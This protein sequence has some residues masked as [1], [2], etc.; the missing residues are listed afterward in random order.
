MRGPLGSPVSALLPSPVLM[1]SDVFL[2]IVGTTAGGGG[3]AYCI[4]SAAEGVLA[5][6]W[7]T[8]SGLVTSTRIDKH[9][10]RYGPR[11][12]PMVTYTYQVMGTSH[13]GSRLSFWGDR[14]MSSDGAQKKL[15][16]YPPGASITVRYHPQRPDRSVLEHG[17]R[18]RPIL[19]ASIFA[20]L[21]VAGVAAL[22]RVF[23]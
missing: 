21:L 3:L 4:W 7:P 15:D 19:S 17:L 12:E 9:Y 16:H 20:L 2:G 18:L 1:S 11:Y 23:K 6:R 22:A 13:T 14:S 8:V 10:T 5:A